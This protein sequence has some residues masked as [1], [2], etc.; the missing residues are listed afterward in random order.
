MN[1]FHCKRTGGYA[2]E[3]TEAIENV[4]LL[5]NILG[6]LGW[7]ANAVS[8][9]AG[10]IGAESGYNPWRWQSDSI[11]T[12]TGSPWRNKG[13]GLVQFTNAGKYINDSRAKA[14]P[15]YGPNFSDKTGRL[16]DGYAQTLFIDAFGDYYATSAYPLSFQEFK[17]SN[18]GADYLASAF[19]YNYER[20]EDPAATEATRRANALYW[21]SILSGETPVPPDP[22]TPGGNILPVWLLFKIREGYTK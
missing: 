21:Y 3:S 2:K 19:L 16:T 18:E 10:N 15:G 5:Y 7:T 17:N 14:L 22:P 8:G 11:G 1:E 12:S 4:K 20:P 13:Y 6:S 9:L